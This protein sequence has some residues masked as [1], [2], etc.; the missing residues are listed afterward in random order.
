[1]TPTMLVSCLALSLSL[2]GG[3]VLFK[4]AAQDIA[5]RSADGLLAAATSP[6][7]LAALV[8]YAAS[9][10]LWIWI[11]TVLPLSRA[12]PFALIAAVLVPVAA[13]YLFGETLTLRYGIGFAFVVFGLLL[14]QAA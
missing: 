12:Y 11:L 9:T 10:A 7:L 5:R 8:L 1:M 2:A 14:T 4:Y 3:Q 13:H 6:W